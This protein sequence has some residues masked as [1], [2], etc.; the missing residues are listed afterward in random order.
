MTYHT[1]NI[2]TLSQSLESNIKGGLATSFL[3]LISFTRSNYVF[4][5]ARTRLVLNSRCRVQTVLNVNGVS[6]MVFAQYTHH[7][8]HFAN[9]F[10][11]FGLSNTLEQPLYGNPE[12]AFTL[13]SVATCN[14]SKSCKNT[15]TLT[16]S[17]TCVLI[18][19]V[20]ASNAMQFIQGAT[21][22]LI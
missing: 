18:N 16:Q 8:A 7:R 22:Y 13:T 14:V 2:L 9:A 10:N 6:S 11:L 3:S 19:A 15:L 17:A 5:V 4:G 21:Y 20:G 12:T 1:G